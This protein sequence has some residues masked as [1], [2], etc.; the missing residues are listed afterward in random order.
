MGCRESQRG[1][2]RIADRPHEKRK[3]KEKRQT[4]AALV[5]VS[6]IKDGRTD[7][8]RE[9]AGGTV[10]CCTTAQTSKRTPGVLAALTNFAPQ[11]V[12]ADGHA[13]CSSVFVQPRNPSLPRN[14]ANSGE[15]QQAAQDTSTR[16]TREELYMGPDCFSCTELYMGPDVSS[17][18]R[19]VRVG[20][21]VPAPRPPLVRFLNTMRRSR[22]K[23]KVCSDVVVLSRKRCAILGFFPLHWG[24]LC[25]PYEVAARSTRRS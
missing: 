12:V 8:R 21:R 15:S 20:F 10:C 3:S 9:K 17:V 4:A 25:T 2:D 1:I 24:T 16:R 6:S 22:R 19:F 7:E 23:Y 13:T 18:L 5:F 11:F 14:L